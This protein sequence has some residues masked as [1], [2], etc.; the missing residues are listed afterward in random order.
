MN[1]SKGPKSVLDAVLV[2]WKNGAQSERMTD[3]CELYDQ[4]TGIS[5]GDREAIMRIVSCTFAQLTD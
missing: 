4:I 3:D 2:R 5:D 1:P